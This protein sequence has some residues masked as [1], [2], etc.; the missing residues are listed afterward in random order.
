MIKKHRNLIIACCVIFAAF[1][2]GLYGYGV[3]S[4][5]KETIVIAYEN[6]YSYITEYVRNLMT[7][8]KEELNVPIIMPFEF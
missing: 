8:L 6:F 3:A 5:Y 1:L 7:F 2:V 4:S